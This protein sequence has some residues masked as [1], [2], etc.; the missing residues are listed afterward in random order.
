[1]F[2]DSTTSAQ[3]QGSTLRTI[4]GRLPLRDCTYYGDYRLGP[5]P[6]NLGILLSN[7]VGEDR[8]NLACDEC[9]AMA[10]SVERR[11]RHI[12]TI[13]PSCRSI[14]S[15]PCSASPDSAV[16]RRRNSSH[17]LGCL[18]LDFRVVARVD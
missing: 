3:R 1:M 16:K 8:D 7:L 12:S 2:F 4:S 5:D 15:Q 6:R 13:E 14:Q 11:M 9:V 17:T 10:R 18:G